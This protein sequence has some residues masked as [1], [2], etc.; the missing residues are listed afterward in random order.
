MFSKK[1]SELRDPASRREMKIKHY[2]AEKALRQRLEVSY[3]KYIHLSLIFI[4]CQTLLKRKRQSVVARG[5]DDDFELI[6]S[7]LPTSPKNDQQ[8]DEEDDEVLRES[9]LLGIRLMWV[10]AQGHLE[11]MEQ[12]F[13]L[14]RTAPPPPPSLP[15]ASQNADQDDTW[16]LE[17]TASRG[18]PDVKG[19][20]MDSSGRVRD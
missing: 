16:R 7:M 15:E 14:L 2:K 19:P 6:A 9:Y 11:N 10:Q 18:G 4:F 8:D 20:L 3:D 12:E 1:V 5:T 13:E 17:P